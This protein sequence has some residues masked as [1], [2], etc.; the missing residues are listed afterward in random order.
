MNDELYPVRNIS[1]NGSR[2]SIK[3]PPELSNGVYQRMRA[4]WEKNPLIRQ[5]TTPIKDGA[6]CSV[7][8]GEGAHYYT[9]RKEGGEP[10]LEPGKPS[11]PDLSF[12]L[13]EGATEHLLGLLENEGHDLG[14]MAVEILKG[15]ISPDPQRKIYLS[16]HIGFL[17]LMRKGYPGMLR[18]A[19]PKALR[20][21][22]QRGYIGHA[23]IKR[24]VTLIKKRREV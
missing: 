5:A 4:I 16:L 15:I 1:S 20:F 17:S 13:S 2:V 24:L 8:F 11:H 7:Q 19:G 6:S 23:G 14:E 9:I 22:A 3:D 12:R 21:I 10:I 18:L